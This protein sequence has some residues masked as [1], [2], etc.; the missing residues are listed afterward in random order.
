M[1]DLA[2]IKIGIL[3]TTLSTIFENIN[4][5]ILRET[6]YK[7]DRKKRMLNNSISIKNN[8]TI[9]LELPTKNFRSR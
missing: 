2:N 9:F 6:V 3:F 1:T 7:T 5:Q 4:G 8:E